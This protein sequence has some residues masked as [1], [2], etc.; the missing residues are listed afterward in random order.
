MLAISLITSFWNSLITNNRH[1][2]PSS[3]GVLYGRTIEREGIVRT[4]GLESVVSIGEND[5][6]GVDRY[7]CDSSEIMKYEGLEIESLDGEYTRPIPQCN[8]Q[9]WPGL[10][11]AMRCTLKRSL[12]EHTDIV[13]GDYGA[14]GLL[15]PPL[16]SDS[17]R[18]I[19]RWA[20]MHY[21][22]LY[23]QLSYGATVA[24]VNELEY[25]LKNHLPKDVRESFFI[26]DGQ[27]RGG[28][29]TG[30]IF[31][32]TLL[33][34]E[35]VLEEYYLWKKV[36]INLTKIRESGTFLRERELFKRQGSYPRGSV[37]A[38]YAHPGWIPLGKDFEGNNIG[39]DL[40]PGPT[41][42]WGQV[43]LFGRDQ[44][45]KYVVAH[46]WASFLAML[47]DD[48]EEGNW[49]IDDTTGEL[50][51]GTSDKDHMSY[52]DVLKHRLRKRQ[53]EQTKSALSM[54]DP[55]KISLTF[56]EKPSMMKISN[57]D[58]KKTQQQQ[59]QQQ[60]Y[61]DTSS[62]HLGSTISPENTL[63]FQNQSLTK[64]TQTTKA[65]LA[66][67]DTNILKDHSHGNDITLQEMHTLK[68]NVHIFS[69][70]IRQ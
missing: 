59:Q 37:R 60:Q 48:L 49:T 45:I 21:P 64:N 53:K 36:A 19:D 68:E 1:A 42:R 20:E 70:N 51:L 58:L 41:G 55:N 25:E 24:D 39:V 11:F 33:D 18:R 54:M 52:F 38:V 35:E 4:E 47:A 30:I 50:F 43:I 31:G 17:W 62:I 65:V 61:K 9:D 3:S 13:L 66:T 63:Y 10:R 57:K 7:L 5:I 34:C 6:R 40:A 8:V 44:D 32:I 23:D 69:P 16:V 2:D 12:Y 29:P 56:N 14:D 15:P 27:E 46:S 26:H 67:K 28:K 22:E